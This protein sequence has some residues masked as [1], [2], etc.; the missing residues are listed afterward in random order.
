VA[1]EVFLTGTAAEVIAV[2]KVDNRVIGNGKPGELTRELE[3]RFKE[4]ARM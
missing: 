3:K 1:D 4:Y 2:V